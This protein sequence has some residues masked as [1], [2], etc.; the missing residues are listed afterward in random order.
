MTKYRIFRSPA[1]KRQTIGFV[2]F[3]LA[4]LAAGIVLGSITPI[5]THLRGWVYGGRG[6][7]DFATTQEIYGILRSDFDGTLDRNALQDGANAGVVVGTGDMFSRYLTPAETTAFTKRMRGGTVGIGVELGFKNGNLV[8]IAPQ[9]GSPAKQAGL[10]KGDI[11]TAIDGSRVV[12]MSEQEAVQALR[13]DAGTSVRLT[14]QRGAEQLEFT[15]TRQAIV[16]PSVRYSITDDA[17]GVMTITTF[18]ANTGRLAAAAAA[19]FQRQN[20][21]GIVVDLRDNPGGAVT[22]AQDVLGLWLPKGSLVMTEKRNGTVLRTY[23]TTKQPVLSRTP[24]VLLINGG[25]ASASEIVAGALHEYDKATN[26]GEQSFGKGSVQEVRPLS[27]GGALSFTVSR[28]FTP[29]G[30]SIDGTGVTP[31]QIVALSRDDAVAGRDPQMEAALQKL[32]S[33]E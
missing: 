16:I 26:I 15:I 1:N 19:A 20:V 32:I 11:I 8:I 21:R 4:I 3:V 12:D 2:G 17:I 22:A 25:S 14:V 30:R 5:G 23:K 10:Q 6:D 29:K 33:Q 27:N 13:G 28:W 24:T 31:D 9:D 18:D 7:L